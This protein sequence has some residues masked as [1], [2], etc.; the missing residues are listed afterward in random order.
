MR[1]LLI[2]TVCLIFFMFVCCGGG[3]S[4]LVLF[5]F[6]SDSELDRFQWK[7][8]TLFSLSDEHIT[9]GARSLRLELY[10]SDYPGLITELEKN[11]WR[12]FKALCFDIY[13]PEKRKIWI[14]VRIEDRKD[15]PNY[16]DRYSKNYSLEP[17][18]NRVTIP[19]NTLLTS[20]T[21][22]NLD[23]KRIS[24]LLI[25]SAHPQNKVVLYVDY[26]RLVS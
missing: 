10:P 6:E 21:K 13:N 12:R 19:L 16:D 8:H 18:L 7:C 11:D 3:S 14:T 2:F 4:E 9:H 25:F 17:G 15:Y 26:I 1:F 24:R 5:D 20:G 23:Q 22:R